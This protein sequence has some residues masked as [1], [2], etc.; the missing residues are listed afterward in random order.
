MGCQC[1]YTKPILQVGSQHYTGSSQNTENLD[2]LKNISPILWIL[3]TLN[4]WP[5]FLYYWQIMNLMELILFSNAHPRSDPT[6]LENFLRNTHNKNIFITAVL[7]LTACHYLPCFNVTQLYLLWT[8]DILRYGYS[9]FK[10]IM[11]L[12]HQLRCPP[13]ERYEIEYHLN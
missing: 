3:C 7:R 1:W 6:H 4:T 12:S 8:F 13:E 9:Y 11:P 2:F 10:Q 5:V